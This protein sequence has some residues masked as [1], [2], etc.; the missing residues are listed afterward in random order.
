MRCQVHIIHAVALASWFLLGATPARA[1]G[2]LTHMSG[3]VS[4]Q[5]V[6]GS[7]TVGAA[8]TR[9]GVGDT[10]VTGSRSYVRMEMTDGGEMVLRPESQLLLQSY[11]FTEDKRSEDSLVMRM[12]KG[13]MRTV[14]G[15]ISKRGNRDAYRLITPTATVG[16]RGTQFDLRVCEGNCGSLP[17]GTY[18]AVRFGAVEAAS[19]QGS[20]AVAAGQVARVPATGAPVILPRDPGIGFTPPAV[21]PKLDEKKKQAAQQQAAPVGNAA[22]GQATP[23]AGATPAQAQ[24]NQQGGQQR[25]G[26]GATASGGAAAGGAGGTGAT[27]TTDTTGATGATGATGTTGTTGTTGA[28]GATDSPAS[29]TGP[30]TGSGTGTG[31]D[32]GSATGSGTMTGSGSGT[33]TGTSPGTSPSPGNSGDASGRAPGTSIPGSVSAPTGAQSVIGGGSSSLPSLPSLF[34]TPLSNP[35]A[36]SG[37]N[38]RVPGAPESSG[39]SGGMVCEVQ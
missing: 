6:D 23:A 10:L 25:S 38:L 2:T 33:S 36:S 27:S 17:N 12:I 21:I 4:V 1:E 29:G 8:G 13:G 34:N 19:P 37:L 32:G 24:S 15:L 22:G 5:K 11:A 7:V 28:T 35:F 18:V 31:S 30:G 26:Q 16:I 20:L 9:I 3:S 14:T 39:S